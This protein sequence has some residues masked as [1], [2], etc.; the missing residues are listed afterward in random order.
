MTCIFSEICTQF[1]S[2]GFVKRYFLFLQK[3]STLSKFS[4][5]LRFS[6][7]FKG[8]LGREVRASWVETGI[9]Q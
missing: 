6:A 8:R 9:T 4:Y 2:W 3:R 1:L 7:Y 5:M